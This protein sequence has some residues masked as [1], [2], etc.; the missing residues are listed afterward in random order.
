MSTEIWI[1]IPR[2]LFDDT[3]FGL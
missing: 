2:E 1:R 3:R